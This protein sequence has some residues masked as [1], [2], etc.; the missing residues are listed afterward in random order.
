M[1][2][3][4][5]LR[6]FLVLFAIDSESLCRGCSLAGVQERCILFFN[7]STVRR[8]V[9][10][11][12]LQIGDAV[13]AARADPLQVGERVVEWI[14]LNRMNLVD[15]LVRVVNLETVATSV[16]EYPRLE[17]SNIDCE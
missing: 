8:T 9:R 12:R 10:I 1:T 11:V 16:G 13:A 4:G 2:L 17:T 6:A 3:L 14:V 7:S 5:L 15:Y